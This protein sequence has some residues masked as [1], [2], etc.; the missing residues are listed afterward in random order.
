MKTYSD[1]LNKSWLQMEFFPMTYFINS[2]LYKTDN[3][4]RLLFSDEYTII[5]AFCSLLCIYAIRET[6]SA[7]LEIVSYYMFVFYNQWLHFIFLLLISLLNIEIFRKTW[8]IPNIHRLPNLIFNHT[9]GNKCVI[10]TGEQRKVIWTHWRLH[11]SNA[12]FVF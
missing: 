8:I 4:Y 3:W 12:I 7:S 1:I 2:T 5:L 10:R 9:V 6:T 11:F